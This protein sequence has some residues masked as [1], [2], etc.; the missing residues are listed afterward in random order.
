MLPE[1]NHT[2]MRSSTSSGSPKKNAALCGLSKYIGG[3]SVGLVATYQSSMSAPK[4]P[5]CHRRKAL[6]LL[7][8]IALE[9][10]GLHRAPDQRVQLDEAR[11]KTDLRDIARPRE[12]D[13]E[14]ADRM[15]LRT[16]R[17]HHH[18]I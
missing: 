2:Q 18:A 15:R 10:F 16:C 7:P 14:L 6:M 13:L 5:S 9:H 1:L 8:G 3:S 12:V 11:R 17:K 4:S